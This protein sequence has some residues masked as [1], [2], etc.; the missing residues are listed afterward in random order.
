VKPGQYVAQ[1][2]HSFFLFVLELSWLSLTK[3]LLC[4]GT[5]SEHWQYLKMLEN[6]CLM[7]LAKL[8]SQDKWS[9]PGTFA[10]SAFSS[11]QKNPRSGR[12][13]PLNFY[14]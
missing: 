5:C 12:H 1:T 4:A 9:N 6:F 7:L 2:R 8:S 3:L 13:Y 10:N 11:A 14:G